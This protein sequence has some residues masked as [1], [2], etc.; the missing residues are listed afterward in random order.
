MDNYLT[1][2]PSMVEF[3]FQCKTTQQMY[4]VD[5]L[6]RY[7]H[8]D[9]PDL[10]DVLDILVSELYEVRLGKRFLYGESAK[11]LARLFLLCFSD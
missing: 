9:M 1:E 7:G 2:K 4:L 8:L 6:L 11:Q 5:A 3:N 10:S